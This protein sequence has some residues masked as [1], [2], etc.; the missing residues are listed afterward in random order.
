MPALL[1]RGQTLAGEGN[2]GPPSCWLPSESIERISCAVIAAGPGE[3]VPVCHIPRLQ[4]LL[5]R[6]QKLLLHLHNSCMH[7]YERAGQEPC[8]SGLKCQMA[9][10]ESFSESDSSSST[11]SNNQVVLAIPQRPFNC[12]ICLD[13]IEEETSVSW[14]RHAFCF[15]C[16]LEWSRIRRICPVCQEPFRYLFHKVG[17]NNYEVYY[18]SSIRHNPGRRD[19]HHSADRRRHHSAGHG[20]RR[21]SS[22]EHGNSRARDWERDRSRSQ[23]QSHDGHSRGQQARSFDPS[24]SRRRPHSRARDMAS[25]TSRGWNQVAR[26]ERDVPVPLGRSEHRQRV[27]WDSSRESWAT[28]RQSRRRSHRIWRQTQ[29]EEQRRRDH[30]EGQPARPEQDVPDSSGRSE[31]HQPA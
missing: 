13:S 14:C 12:P 11:T 16:I 25:E 18:T 19:R 4:L 17:D 26:H 9:L 2:D 22:R 5:L 1:Q 20:H 30:N 29:R 21:S 3:L 8:V 6:G 15:S 7:M 23:R 28:S 31:H 10:E 24:S 27:P